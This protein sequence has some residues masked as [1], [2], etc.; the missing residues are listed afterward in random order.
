MP[1]SPETFRYLIAREMPEGLSF[2]AQQQWLMGFIDSLERTVIT[3]AAV[4]RAAE[5]EAE[6]NA[7]HVKQ[8]LLACK[9]GLSSLR[10]GGII[11]RSPETDVMEDAINK[12]EK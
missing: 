10:H 7:D 4:R 2:D 6:K 1:F 8:L 5:N 9:V 3:Q 12:V 11:G